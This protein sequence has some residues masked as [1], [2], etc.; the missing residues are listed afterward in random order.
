M[1][2]KGTIK[3]E[4]LDTFRLNNSKEGG[5]RMDLLLKETESGRELRATTARNSSAGYCF[6]SSLEYLRS[7]GEF[8]LSYHITRAG[9]IIID[10]IESGYFQK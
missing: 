4:V 6:T 1:K 9:N 3:A 2:K 5:P 10:R 7:C 8:V